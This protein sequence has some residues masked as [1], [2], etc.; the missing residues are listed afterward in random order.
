MKTEA[1]GSK[2]STWTDLGKVDGPR[3]A[4]SLKNAIHKALKGSEF[5]TKLEKYEVEVE[6][7]SRTPDITITSNKKISPKDEKAKEVKGKVVAL[8]KQNFA[9]I[10]E[11]LDEEISSHD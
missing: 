8:T 9:V 3:G 2:I 6:E 1:R 11:K 10:V 4:K 5:E 7:K